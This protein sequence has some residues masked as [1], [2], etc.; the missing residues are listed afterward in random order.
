MAPHG[1]YPARDEDTWV[2]IACRDDHDWH[3]LAE[4]AGS[5]WGNDSRFVTLDGRLEHEDDLDLLVSGWTRQR[6]PFETAA[7]LQA[8]GVPATA[9]Q[10]PEQRIDRDPN[11]QA[12]GLWPEVEQQ[13]MGAVRVDGLPVHMSASDWDLVHGG[14]S[15]GQHNDEV[16]GGLLGIS[17]TEIAAL[18]EEGVI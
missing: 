1:I 12:W 17:D 14:P 10:S 4:R 13:A 2:A 9:V 8:A 3:A 6:D 7:L 5:G 16:Y 18:R 11:T 15:L